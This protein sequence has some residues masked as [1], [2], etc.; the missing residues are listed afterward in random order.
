MWFW[1]FMVCMDLM[2]PLM[3]IGFGAVF[4]KCPPGEINQVFG[5]RTRRSMKNKETWEFAHAYFAK[6]WIRAG[7]VML[8][9]SVLLMLP[10]LGKSAEIVGYV[11][12]AVCLLECVGMIIPIIPTERALKKQFDEGGNS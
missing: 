12:G 1:I 6:M 5:Y 8:P 10:V 9:I 7:L 3:M 11:G 4:K 2:V